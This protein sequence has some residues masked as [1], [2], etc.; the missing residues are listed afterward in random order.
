MLQEACA[1]A[2]S[3]MLDDLEQQSDK[4]VHIQAAVEEVKGNF[5]KARYST[6]TCPL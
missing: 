4:L 5:E 3:M 2:D 1:A 6:T